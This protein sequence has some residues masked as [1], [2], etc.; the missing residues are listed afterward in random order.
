MKKIQIEIMEDVFAQCMADT[1]TSR[2]FNKEL[3]QILSDHKEPMLGAKTIRNFLLERAFCQGKGSKRWTKN[4]A[5]AP[6]GSGTDLIA[7]ALGRMKD[8]GPSAFSSEE[9]LLAF[10][11][12]TLKNMGYKILKTIEL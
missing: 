10:C 6:M 12:R 5:E 9:A 3:K 8:P 1:F 7:E 11:V 2:E 4:P